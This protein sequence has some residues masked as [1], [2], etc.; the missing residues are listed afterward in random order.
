MLQWALRRPAV[1]P[2]VEA[3]SALAKEFG[4]LFAKEPTTAKKLLATGDSVQYISS[5]HSDLQLA[6]WTMV[7]N[8]V[9]NRDDFVTR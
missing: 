3:M 8:A 1:K 2:D 9:M 4:E 5:R 6:A 7:A